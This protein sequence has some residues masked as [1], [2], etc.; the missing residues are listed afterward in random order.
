MPD[1][2]T[3]LESIAAARKGDPLAPVTLV[4][5]SHVAALQLR[6]LLAELTPFAGV[7]FE[8]LPRIAELLGAGY[9]ATAGRSPLARPIGDYVAEQVA[10]ESRGVLARV[11]DLPGYARVLRHMF[12]RLR[13]GGIRL[14]Q[15][16]ADGQATGHLRE[17]LRLYDRFREETALFY[18]EEDL[19][20]AAAEAV[21]SGKAGALA[22]LGTIYV[23][24]PGAQSAGGAALLSALREAAPAY[25][26]L[27][28]PRADP[29]MRFVLAPDP[30]SEA[31]EAVREVLW[32]L[33]SSLSLHEIAVFHGAGAA[34]PRLLREAFDMA[35]VPAVPLPGV[36]LTETQAGRAALALALLPDRDFSRTATVDF[37]SVAPLREWLPTAEGNVRA[38]TSAWDRLSREAGITHGSERWSGA[39][40]ALI[41]DREESLASPAVLEN[42]A[43]VRAL[44][45]E[46]GRAREL[47]AVVEALVA[48]LEPLR[49]P[50]PAA[51]FIPAFTQVVA[52]Y[53]D[54]GARGLP[55]VIRE[56]EQLGTVGAVAG[57]F[58]LASFA[59]SLAANLEAATIRER[60]LGDGVMVADYRLAAGLRFKHVI[61]CGAYE[62]AFPAGPGA[63]ALVQD[64]AWSRLRSRHPYV[65]DASLRLERA[66][67]AAQRAVT[68]AG[69]GRVIWCAP[70]Y[71]PGGT[72]E[73]YPS[74]MMVAAAARMDATLVTAS[75][76]RRRGS[77]EWLR[78]GPSPLALML[79]GPVVDPSEI[80][81]RRAI[82]QRREGVA[83]GP[84]H[85]RW[86]PLS[87]L[88][89]RR[90]R[91]F[92]EWDGNVGALAGEAWLD[93]ARAVS[94]TSL[95]NYGVCGFRYLCHSILRLNTV[96]EPEER[97][98][99]DPAA[100]GTLIHK[101]L[102]EFFSEQQRQGRPA[103]GEAWTHEDF[104][105][106]AQITTHKLA[107]ARRRGLTGLD[108]YSQHEE[109]TI[110][111]D[112]ATFLEED[113][114]FRRRTGAVPAEFEAP[115]PEVSVAGVTLRG[116]VDR[117]DRTPDG[118]SAWVIDY[119][120]GSKRDF[121]GIRSDEDPLA[122]GT[123]LQLPTYVEAA[124]GAE[125]VTAAY[126]FITHRG[127]FSFINYFP[128]P[129]RRDLFER[130]LRA[131]IEG[132]RSGAFPAVSGE[133]SEFYGG[134]ENCTYCDFDRICPRRRD[135]ELAA[136]TQDEGFS[137]WLRVGRT[138]RG[139]D[140]G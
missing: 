10:R 25:D 101:V 120:S 33:D 60:N 98:M 114:A 82:L 1:V 52:D 67:E 136:K 127:E 126:W 38:L 81:V 83:I 57:S 5:A 88:R 132:I 21:R 22:D 39:L 48:R 111:A 130:T 94:P 75:E 121:E 32:A 133:E 91:R 8:T 131:I 77:S 13:R 40:Q 100:R 14:S 31:R 35:G 113:T 134:F 138:A 122:G 12:R 128:T 43:R 68:A 103:P 139:E 17:I 15:D 125:E 115:I 59:R 99:M 119:K 112:L 84:E 87:M 50:Q 107:E 66:K 129:E 135:Y 45:L 23:L 97:E 69:P 92:T 29:E 27:D 62:G 104:A 36:P 116:Y 90:S 49:A 58:S 76:L 140:G 117:V 124:R 64:S 51:A 2:H 7:R 79:L 56:I 109:R 6:R 106:L 89:A 44:E 47:H 19:L 78:R 137:P 80:L 9:L 108:V 18:D 61:L 93:M 102:Q 63:D 73:Y 37:L 55:E 110:L 65:E 11:G 95:E 30:A 74:S 28:E 71:E 54:P 34:Y 26:E 118:R 70:T 123:K 3:T 85:P 86:K 46:R 41:A 72:R 53:F 24:P 16:A 42:E 20:E 96:E 105:L 4:V